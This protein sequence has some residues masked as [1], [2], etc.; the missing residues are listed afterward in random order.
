MAKRVIMGK[1]GTGTGD[2]GLRV[3]K[4][5]E[6]AINANGTACNVDN[7][8]FDSRNPTGSLALYKVFD[9]VV[10]AGSGGTGGQMRTPTTV[11]QAFGETLG[12]IPFALVNRVVSSTLHTTE[13]FTRSI[14]ALHLFGADSHGPD[15][16][17][18]VYVTTTSNIT[19][20][21]YGA[22]SI[23]VRAAL[24]YASV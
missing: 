9:I 1:F 6:D 16:D 19:I 14:I 12:F 23:T 10:G 13:Y 21:N 11:A 18:F 2:Y 4:S 15:D 24:F 17:G 8:V 7:L 5:G 3:S 22:S 20:K